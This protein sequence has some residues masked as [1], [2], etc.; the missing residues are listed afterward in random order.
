MIEQGSIDEARPIAFLEYNNTLY[1][2]DVNSECNTPITS[3]IQGIHARLTS[4]AFHALRNRIYANY[5]P[6]LYCRE[7]IK[8][9]AKRVTHQGLQLGYNEFLKRLKIFSSVVYLPAPFHD[10]PKATTTATGKTLKPSEVF[11]YLNTLISPDAPDTQVSAALVDERGELL[12]TSTH[13]SFDPNRALHAELQILFTLRVNEFCNRS[14]H[15]LRLFTTL[16]PCR[17]CAAAI[18]HTVKRP[19]L[20]EIIYRDFDLGPFGR[21]TLLDAPTSP[22]KQT[23]F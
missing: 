7:T 6:S 4:K 3:L 5:E 18:L 13:R 17:M 12:F 19:Q 1:W 22:I 21:K 8:V 10:L 20:L 2:S 14:T 9:A 23:K 16:K 15:P 11:E